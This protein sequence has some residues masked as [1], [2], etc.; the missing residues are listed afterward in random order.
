MDRN[1]LQVCF[2]A[3]EE[4]TEKKYGTRFDLRAVENSVAAL[5]N[6][7]PLTYEDLRDFESPDKWSFQ[8]FWVFPPEHHVTRELKRQKFNFWRL[9]N[10]EKELIASLLDVFKSIELVSVI[11]RFIRPE[12]YGIISPPV[13]RILDVRRVG[14]AVETYLN[15][16]SDLRA[17]ARHYHFD[18]LAD[19]DMALWVLHERC[20][21]SVLDG[22]T[23]KA[24]ANDLFILAL[25]AK[26]LIAHFLPDSS[27]YPQVAHALLETNRELA[28]QIA[29]IAFE[30]MV[31][32]RV[33]RGNDA[34]EKKTG[35]W[36]RKR[37]TVFDRDRHLPLQFRAFA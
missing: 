28:A 26:N 34:K 16:L 15:Y 11:L 36:R 31:R 2:E 30:R 23:Q 18:R 21:G 37:L 4:V 33:P 8:K 13:E 24:Y 20:F 29:G 17:V 32:Q 3:F 7:R 14:D 19:A 5:R 22:G 9:P 6:K 27:H 1:Y 25:R 12:H 10:H 35:D